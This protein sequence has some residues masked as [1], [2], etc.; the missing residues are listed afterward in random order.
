[1]AINAYFINGYW[2]IILVAI[3]V[4]LLLMVIDGYSIYGYLWL[5]VVINDYFSNGY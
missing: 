3:N 1:V 2:F 4:F 5:L